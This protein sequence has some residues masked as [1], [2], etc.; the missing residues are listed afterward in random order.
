MTT[1]SFTLIFGTKI[2]CEYYILE[3]KEIDPKIF[4]MELI[5]LI[6]FS[7]GKKDIINDNIFMK[8]KKIN[9]KNAMRGICDFVNSIYKNIYKYLGY[10]EYFCKIWILHL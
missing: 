5:D 9:N 8:N 6:D 10:E 1:Y 2:L 3:N 4:F 7:S